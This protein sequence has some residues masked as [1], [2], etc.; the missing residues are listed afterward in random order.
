MLGAMRR[1]ICVGAQGVTPRVDDIV[2]VSAGDVDI[3]LDC[4]NL[5]RVKKESPAPR[6]FVRDTE[7]VAEV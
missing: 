3:V 7:P 5:T 4:S 6:A 2:A 1:E